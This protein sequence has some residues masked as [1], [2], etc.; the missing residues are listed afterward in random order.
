MIKFP[1][2]FLLLIST[3]LWAETTPGFR[4]CGE[5]L[6]KGVLVK[7]GSKKKELGIVLYKTNM[8]TISEMQFAVKEREDLVLV[9][10]YLD[11]PTEIKAHIN[12]IMNGTSGEI[13]HISKVSLRKSNPL[14]PFK[15]SG[16]FLITPTPCH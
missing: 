2:L 5:Y 7:N 16:I 6:L 12:K 10:S 1:V 9:S 8:K 4:G 14:E 11:K 13:D 15:D 3:G